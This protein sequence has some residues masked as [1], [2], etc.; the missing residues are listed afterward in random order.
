MENIG[1]YCEK[2]KTLEYVVQHGK[3]WSIL[4][5]KG[6]PAASDVMSCHPAVT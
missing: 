6:D 1:I 4:Y 3:Y 5:N 2:W